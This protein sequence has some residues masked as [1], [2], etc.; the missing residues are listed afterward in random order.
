MSA[1]AF[2]PDRCILQRQKFEDAHAKSMKAVK[3]DC[4]LKSCAVW[5]N[6]TA[7]TIRQNRI[8]NEVSALIKERRV[9]ALEARRKKLSVLLHGVSCPL[10][11]EFILVYLLGF[12]HVTHQPPKPRSQEQKTYEAE[13]MQKTK[14][15]PDKM[16]QKM[17]ARAMDLKGRRESER[18][19]FVH[20]K[21]YQQWRQSI[22]ELRQQDAKLFELQVGFWKFVIA[23][24]ALEQFRSCG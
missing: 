2:R 4:N 16:K 13:L 15:N 21:L 6:K 7:G 8:N 10:P 22:D 17:I 9:D 18:E 14:P 19:R 1:A 5:E 3:D 11:P 24:Q 12:Q 23:T 20:E